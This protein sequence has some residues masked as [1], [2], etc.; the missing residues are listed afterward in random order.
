MSHGDHVFLSRWWQ[1]QVSQFST[2]HLLFPFPL[3]SRISL[4]GSVFLENPKQNYLQ[5]HIKKKCNVRKGCHYRY[6]QR[7]F[8]SQNCVELKWWKEREEVISSLKI[9]Q[10]RVLGK[11]WERH[12][13][14]QNNPQS[15]KKCI[16]YWITNQHANNA[17]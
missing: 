7:S 11:C 13:M 4:K 12:V 5:R 17:T 9:K 10:G 2:V 3:S 1:W 15:W 8:N 14:M 6:F 16:H